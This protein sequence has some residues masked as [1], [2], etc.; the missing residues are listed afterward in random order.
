M[1]DR[2][3]KNNQNTDDTLRNVANKYI[4]EKSS[5]VNQ[6][7][8]D[9][10]QEPT[11]EQKVDYHDQFKP[12]GNKVDDIV[13]SQ[14]FADMF[15]SKEYQPKQPKGKIVKQAVNGETV[16]EPIETFSHHQPSRPEIQQQYYEQPIPQQVRK[17]AQ[18]SHFET[19]QPDNR[20]YTPDQP[21]VQE[22]VVFQN[23][24]SEP[25]RTMLNTKNVYF[26]EEVAQVKNFH[27]EYTS[28]TRH[29]NENF[30]YREIDI[31]TFPLGA[32]Y[33]PNTRLQI[34]PV[35]LMEIQHIAT[36]DNESVTEARN[37]IND[38]LN[39]CIS[40][41]KSDGSFGTID[42]VK[43]GDRLYLILLLRELTFQEGPML[44]VT[45][46]CS[47]KQ[48]VKIELVRA[49]L[50]FL[51][52]GEE[53]EPYWDAI[54]NCFILETSLKRSPILLAP[55]SIGIQTSFIEWAQ[56]RMKRKLPVNE[57][58]FKIVPFTKV[59]VDIINIDEI[60]QELIQ[61]ETKLSKELFIYLDDVINNYMKF[62]VKGLV[63]KCTC[64]LEVR[65]N[66]VLPRRAKD[67]FIIPGAFR[68]FTKKHS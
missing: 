10:K 58:F 52:I 63:K 55:P 61:F 48:T 15:L 11:Q 34:R 56:Y 47:C 45:A 67:L 2:R 39:N 4:Q 68:Q 17:P 6:Q 66:R 51:K 24:F 40:F 44:S 64:G 29:N 21:P 32:F 26:E 19:I 25:S 12:R 65:T 33:H 36:L 7:S 50:E 31:A 59:G 1:S 60:E 42:N 62:G 30:Y 37:K 43:E 9:Y 54:N 41:I 38:L 28:K 23:S 35:E 53:I 49:H 16:D 5:N 27:Q 14:G 22:R 18:R 46:T 3:N 13:N 20:H 57:S 8:P